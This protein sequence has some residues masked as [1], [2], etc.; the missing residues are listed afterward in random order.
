MLHKLP[1]LC[2]GDAKVTVFLREKNARVTFEGNSYMM[3]QTMAAD[4]TRY[5]DGTHVWW[6]K[7]ETGFL[8][9]DTNSSKPVRLADN[10]KLARAENAK[11]DPMVSGTVAYRERM[12]MP[13]SAV[14]TIQLQDISLADAPAKII[15]EQKFAFAGHQV[16][17]PFELH[18]NAKEINPNHKYAL[19]ARIAVNGQLMFVNSTTYPVITQKN[20][21]K[22]D[23]LVHMVEGQTKDPKQ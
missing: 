12:A 11:T 2:D 15:A 10:C 17:L 20:P 7:G 19:S 3:K 13:E 14:L 6:S 1:Y 22:V 5:S 4:G 9:D 23:I 8:E 21:D 18:Y 16:P